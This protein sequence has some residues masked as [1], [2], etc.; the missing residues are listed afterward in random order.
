[1]QKQVKKEPAMGLF[2]RDDSRRIISII[3]NL[4]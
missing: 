1:M 2:I 3:E 4:K